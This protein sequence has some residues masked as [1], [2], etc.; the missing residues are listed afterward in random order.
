M[1]T[2]GERDGGGQ[3][4]DSE[5]VD[6]GIEGHVRSRRTGSNVD[7]TNAQPKPALMT[8]SKKTERQKER[9]GGDTNLRDAVEKYTPAEDDLITSLHKEWERQRGGGI[10]MDRL[11]QIFES[12]GLDRSAIGLQSHILRSEVLK[13][14][15]QQC[16]KGKKG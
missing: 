1:N 4:Y 3:E 7:A 10:P 9:R 12:K 8:N 13:E 6:N 16:V 5:G 14:M 2:I 11:S 15:R